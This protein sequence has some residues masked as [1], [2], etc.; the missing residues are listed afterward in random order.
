VY[1]AN[2]TPPIRDMKTIKTLFKILTP[3]RILI[4]KFNLSIMQSL[5]L[6]HTHTHTHTIGMDIID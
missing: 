2:H 1:A 6:S 3:Q 5:A 4:T